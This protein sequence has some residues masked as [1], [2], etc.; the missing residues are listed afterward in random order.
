MSDDVYTL[1]DMY[2]YSIT[3]LSNIIIYKIK[4]MTQLGDEIRC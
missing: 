2:R 3:V 4:I 1:F